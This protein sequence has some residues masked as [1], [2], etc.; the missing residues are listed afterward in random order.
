MLGDDGAAAVQEGGL[1]HHLEDLAAAV[2]QHHPV[3]RE[4]PALGDALAQIVAVADGIEAQALELGAGDDRGH[5]GLHGLG[6][7]PGILVGGQL[8]DGAEAQLA[9][10][11][12]DGL[13]GHVERDPRQVFEGGEGGE[14]GAHQAGRSERTLSTMPYSRASSAPM[15]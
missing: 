5:A 4:A 11:F 1:G 15:K 2:A 12:L 3:E 7:P 13:A 10:D 9:L 6:G 14:A 8:D